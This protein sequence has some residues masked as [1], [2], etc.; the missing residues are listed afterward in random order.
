[1]FGHSAPPLPVAPALTLAAADQWRAARVWRRLESRWP[2]VLPVLTVVLAIGVDDTPERCAALRACTVPY[3]ESAAPAVLLVEFLVLLLCPRGSFAVPAVTGVLLWLLPNA[4]PGPWLPTVAC[5]A[6]LA[7]AAAL[8]RV[9]AGRRRARAQLVALMGPP[10]PY[11]WTMLGGESPFE[12]PSAPLGRRILAGLLGAGAAVLLLV[13][14]SRT[15]DGIRRAA[16][17]D[18]VRATVRTVHDGGEGATVEYRLPHDTRTLTAEVGGERTV[19]EQ[20]PL[21]VDDAGRT[22]AADEWQDSTPWWL[23]V[24]AT[25]TCAVL[26]VLSAHRTV[27]ERRPAGDG[28]PALRVRVRPDEDG[29]MVVLPLDGGDRESGLWRLWE[30]G[31]AFYAP[32]DLDDPAEWLPRSAH[33]A[34][35]EDDDE[36]DEHDDEDWSGTLAEAAELVERTAVPV[37]A[38]LYQG[39]DG[40]RRQL[41]VFRSPAAPHEWT[42]VSAAARAVPPRLRRDRGPHND[43]VLVTAEAARHVEQDLAEQPDGGPE[44]ARVFGLPTALRC[45]AAPVAAVLIGFAISGTAEG[46]VLG[47]LVRPL[48]LGAAALISV[49]SA[50]GWQLAV[51][52]DGVSCSGVLLRARRA[53]WQQVTA[54]A[55]HRGR[56]TLRGGFREFGFPVLPARLLHRH[57]G[58]PYDPQQIAR[59]V[60]VLAHRPERRPLTALPEGAVGSTLLVNRLALGGYAVWAVAQYLMR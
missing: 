31:A 23:G 22:R 44:P 53:S 52:R 12:P 42:A 30:G 35:D 38:L 6:H 26:L 59:T 14:V 46:G 25:G 13:G 54:A 56:F 3:A 7:V 11:P 1:M 37:E 50:F 28:A 9:A 24:G 29:R 19:G 51:D 20:V 27:R 34:A 40:G 5:A 36:D 55:V 57:F 10:V 48:F 18:E 4:L 45:V 33:E 16:T 49:T 15:E 60:S 58:G 41:L 43:A 8:Y 17:A 39:P 21:L 2:A 47:G 32:A